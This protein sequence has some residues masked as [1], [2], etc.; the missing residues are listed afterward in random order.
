MPAK[1]RGKITFEFEL[2]YEEFRV[3]G[4][5][6]KDTLEGAELGIKI[7]GAIGFLMAPNTKLLSDE[8]S[9]LRIERSE[10]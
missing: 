4:E 3:V 9:D 1:L 5:L 10:N 2:P 8:V 7:M 6:D